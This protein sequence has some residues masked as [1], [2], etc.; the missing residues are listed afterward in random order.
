LRN[1]GKRNP[2]LNRKS[3]I[4]SRKLAKNNSRSAKWIAYD[5]LRELQSD[6]IQYRLKRNNK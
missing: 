5:A 1:I 4:F 2:Y 3:I 6:K